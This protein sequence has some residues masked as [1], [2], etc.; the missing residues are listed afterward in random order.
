[1]VIMNRDDGLD[2]LLDLDGHLIDQGDGYWVKIEVRRLSRITKER[3][4]GIR[5]SLTL[6]GPDGQRIIGYDNAHAIIPIKGNEY[7]GDRTFYDHRHRAIDDRGSP[8]QFSDAYQLLRDFFEDVD[9][10]LRQIK[11][12]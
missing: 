6:H 1:M 10:V 3:P 11:G 5:Y 2:T 9:R 7:A 4:H 12:D 8:Y